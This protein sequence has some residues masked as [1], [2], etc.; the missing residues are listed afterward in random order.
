MAHFSRRVSAGNSCAAA[1]QST[2]VI[3]PL[4]LRWNGT[5]WSAS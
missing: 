3:H 4:M 2:N 1:C 5:R